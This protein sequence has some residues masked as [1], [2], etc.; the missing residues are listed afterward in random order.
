MSYWDDVAEIKCLE[1]QK[2]LGGQRFKSSK[3]KS[4]I[5]RWHA[6]GYKTLWEEGSRNCSLLETFPHSWVRI[7]NRPDPPEFPSPGNLLSSIQNE[8]TFTLDG[9]T[10][11]EIRRI[12]GSLE[13]TETLI[14]TLEDPN[15]YGNSCTGL[16]IMETWDLFIH[17][18]ISYYFEEWEN[19]L[20][21]ANIE[22]RYSTTYWK[23][24]T[25]WPMP[26]GVQAANDAQ[27]QSTS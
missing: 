9:L 2:M 11:E 25:N 10:L 19:D 6:C 5:P 26:S 13:D 24:C 22:F 3:I 17:R 21:Q 1:P 4:R 18:V 8:I 14:L 16:L 7:S 23:P 27:N 12:D 15:G 20:Y